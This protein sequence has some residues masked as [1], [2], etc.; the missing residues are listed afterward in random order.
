MEPYNLPWGAE[1]YAQVTAINVVGSST[2]SEPGSGLIILRAPY[3]PINFE[4]DASITRMDQIGI[5][6]DKA[7][8]EGGTPV[9]DYQ[10][11]LAEVSGSYSVIATGLTETSYT[12]VGLTAGV[13]YKLKV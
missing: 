7:S 5:K 13:T 11:S 3:P 4:N 6:W 2:I 9:I 12:S 8:E 10:V 1:I